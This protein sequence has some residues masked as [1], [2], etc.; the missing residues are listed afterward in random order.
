MQLRR[1]N[2]QR[3]A[4]PDRIDEREFT[5]KNRRARLA[6]LQVGLDSHTLFA[7]QLVIEIQI[8]TSTNVFAIFHS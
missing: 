4:F 5:L 3:P 2:M 7:L 8:Q 1:R 6:R